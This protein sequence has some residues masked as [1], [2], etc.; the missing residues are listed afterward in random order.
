MAAL[1]TTIFHYIYVP[2][3]FSRPIF[4][5]KGPDIMSIIKKFDTGYYSE[6]INKT[7]KAIREVTDNGIIIMENSYYS[8]LGIP[9]SC[10]AVNYD[11]K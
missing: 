1:F 7:A 2:S 9:Y 10:P 3:Y 4:N 6:F 11:G 8:N 5:T